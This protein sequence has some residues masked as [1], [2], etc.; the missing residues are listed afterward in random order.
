MEKSFKRINCPVVVLI[1]KFTF[2]S[3]EDF[4]V[5]IYELPHRPLLIGEKTGGSTGAPL[6]LFN[7]P[8]ETTARICTVRILFPYSMKPFVGTGISPDIEVKE[9]IEDY[10]SG[11]DVVLNRALQSLTN[12]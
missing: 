2:S 9:D 10:I 1:S 3:C 7:L 12:E 11:E 8:N 4:L 5:N 6:V